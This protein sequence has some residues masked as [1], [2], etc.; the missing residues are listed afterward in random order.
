MTARELTCQVPAGD[1]R[2]QT[3]PGISVADHR[4]AQGQTGF[5]SKAA[6]MYNRQSL[7]VYS[8]PAGPYRASAI[9]LV[10][11]PL[12]LKGRILERFWSM[13]CGSHQV[14]TEQWTS[15]SRPRVPA[16]GPNSSSAAKCLF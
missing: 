16:I 9:R 8:A 1:G 4:Q 13:A 6:D 14:Q 5:L 15:A 11:H 3:G 12:N 10:D 2:R 7:G